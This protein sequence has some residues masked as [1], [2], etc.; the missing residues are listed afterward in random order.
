MRKYLLLAT[1]LTFSSIC[2]AEYV[3]QTVSSNDIKMIRS[4][5]S[6][7]PSNGAGNTATIVVEN[8]HSV[9]EKGV[10]L[11]SEKDKAVMSFVL[12]AYMAKRNLDLRFN[13]S[14]GGPWGDPKYC[15]LIHASIVN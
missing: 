6:S 3:A 5:A 8:F 11:D 4:H 10:W 14:S 7:H 1:C 12:A 9:C 13:T 2:S 15:E